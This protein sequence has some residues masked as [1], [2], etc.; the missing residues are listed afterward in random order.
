MREKEREGNINVWLPLAHP[1]W[2][3]WEDLARN[4][5]MCP[6]WESSQRSFGSQACGQSTELHQLG[7]YFLFFFF[8]KK[9]K[10]KNSPL[11]P[12]C[13][14]L[15]GPFLFPFTSELIERTV[16]TSFPPVSLEPTSFRVPSSPTVMVLP[17]TTEATH[18]PLQHLVHPDSHFYQN[19]SLPLNAFVIW[20]PGHH[21]FVVLFSFLLPPSLSFLLIL[22]Y[23]LI[24]SDLE[25]LQFL[26][27]LVLDLFISLSILRT[28]LSFLALKTIS[29]LAI[30][31]CISLTLPSLLNLR[32]MYASC[33][34]VSP[35][36]YLLSIGV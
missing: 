23:L 5:G 13:P 18:C 32:L 17:G 26:R 15:T 24:S 30:L 1:L 3:G 28:A 35:L 10:K 4:Q 2:G 8:K 31:Q 33:C 6:D 11:S 36:G 9:K 14:L 20:P 16:C 27:V 19:C 22:Y 34:P 21:F 12:H 7:L 25:T 29:V